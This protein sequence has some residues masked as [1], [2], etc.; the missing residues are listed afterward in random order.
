MVSI[1]PAAEELLFVT[2]VLRVA[3]EDASVEVLEFISEFSPSILV[4]A[5]ELL[6]VTVPERDTRLAFSDD[7][8][9]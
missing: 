2:V 4:A 1:L 8:A 6:V 3:M 5:E 7:D 9:L